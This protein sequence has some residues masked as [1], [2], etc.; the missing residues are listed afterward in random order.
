MPSLPQVQFHA[1]GI[2]MGSEELFIAI[3][4]QPVKRFRTFTV[5]YHEAIEYLRAHGITTVAMESTGVY[6]VALHDLLEQAGIDVCLVSASYVKHLPGRKSDVVD[7]QWLQQLHA[8]GLLRKSFVPRD[9]IRQL[10][11]YTRLRD[12]HIRLAA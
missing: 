8:H 7:C 2:D 12:D 5:S 4:G 3:D 9:T 6:W 1:A 10:R 11:C